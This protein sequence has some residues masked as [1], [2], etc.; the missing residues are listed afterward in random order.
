M[1]KKRGSNGGRAPSMDGLLICSAI[2]FATIEPGRWSVKLPVHPTEW[3][4][5]TPRSLTYAHALPV[6]SILF[7]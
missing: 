1:E 4:L 3:K 6:S 5:M 2:A 7:P